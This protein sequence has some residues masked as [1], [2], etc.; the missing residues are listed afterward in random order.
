MFSSA[1]K[2]ACGASETC[3]QN[4]DEALSRM[5][6]ATFEPQELMVFL[7]FCADK[8]HRE[9]NSR[10]SSPPSKKVRKLR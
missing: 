7:E 8:I 5:Q 9:R 10:K 3:E 4:S 2:F 6:V 1:E